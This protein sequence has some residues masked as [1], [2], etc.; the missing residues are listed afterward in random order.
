MKKIFRLSALATAT[1]VLAG[2][3]SVNIDQTVQD[4]N[5]TS[6]AFTQG[7]LE[8]NRTAQ[9]QQARSA[10]SADLLAKPLSMDGAV[11]LALTNSPAVQ[12]LLAQGWAY[13]EGQPERTHCQ[14]AFHIRARALRR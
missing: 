5:A 10:L 7:K 2:C 12:T 13:G 9:Q 4:T 3:A 14:S 11:Q 1:L 8:L 6:Q